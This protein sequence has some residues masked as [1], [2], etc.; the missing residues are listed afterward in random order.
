MAELS[1]RD[2]EVRIPARFLKDPAISSDAKALLAVIKSFADGKTGLTFVR[3]KILDEILH[4]G[5]GKREKVQRELC[6]KGWLCL[7]WKRG[8]GR[9]ARR[10]YEVSEPGTVARFQRSGEKAQLI[11]HHSQSQVTS[12]MTTSLNESQISKN[13]PSAESDLT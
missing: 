12:S 4:W 9:W 10:I 1:K 6:E 7:G 13:T 2:F 11:S 3:P 5:R 8:L